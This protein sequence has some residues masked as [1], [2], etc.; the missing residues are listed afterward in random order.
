[1]S[2]P[3]NSFRASLNSA[4]GAVFVG[5]FVLVA[6]A[7]SASVVAQSW[8][9]VD[10]AVPMTSAVMAALGTFFGATYAFLLNAKREADKLAEE[11]TAAINSAIFILITQLKAVQ[12]QIQQWEAHKSSG[13]LPI[14]IT[15]IMPSIDGLQVNLASLQ[16]LLQLGHHGALAALYDCQLSFNHLFAAIKGRADFMEQKIAPVIAQLRQSGGTMVTAADV[17]RAEPQLFAQAE[18]SVRNVE[19]MNKSTFDHLCH[20]IA[21]VRE[22]GVASFPGTKFLNLSQDPSP[23][24][25]NPATV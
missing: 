23:K 14:G 9:R 25:Q 21:K 24:S 12:R 2:D 7:V 11:N 10:L 5:L 20:G 4:E 3:I 16:F 15:V 18:M 17:K 8:F 1:V 19:E 13:Q 6:L 22:V